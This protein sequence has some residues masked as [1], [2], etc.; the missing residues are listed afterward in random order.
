MWYLFR[1]LIVDLVKAILY[2]LIHILMALL[3][4]WIINGD[5]SLI[6]TIGKNFLGIFLG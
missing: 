1:E 4:E 6:Y 3:L 5:D 2:I